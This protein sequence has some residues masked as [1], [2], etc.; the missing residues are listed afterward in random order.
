[1]RDLEGRLRSSLSREAASVRPEPTRLDDVEVRVRRRR[2]AARAVPVATITGAVLAAAVAVP[3]LLPRETTT[4]LGP[5]D[6]APQVQ[7]DPSEEAAPPEPPDSDE[8]ADEP[9]ALN[10]ELPTEPD[11]PFAPL[12]AVDGLLERVPAIVA[13]EDGDA[14]AA[15]AWSGEVWED[16][17]GGRTASG[18]VAVSP[19]AEGTAPSA[20]FP[21]EASGLDPDCET[22]KVL[23]G[24]GDE[25]RVVRVHGAECAGA[26]A[27]SPGGDRLAWIDGDRELRVVALAD[28]L[29]GDG[30]ATVASWQLDA[31]APLELAGWL[32]SPDEW[33]LLVIAGTGADAELHALPVAR[34]ADGAVTLPRRGLDEETAV[35]LDGAVPLAVAPHDSDRPHVSDVDVLAIAD[36]RLVIQAAAR[37]VRL[38]DS[39]AER[40]LDGEAEPWI[41]RHRRDVLVGDG[42]GA[43][44]HVAMPQTTDA[45]AEVVELDADWEAAAIVADGA[46]GP[47]REDA[48]GV[49][50][51]SLPDGI[52]D[53]ARGTW[54]M[55]ARVASEDRLDELPDREP[56]TLEVEVGGE[57]V[58]ALADPEALERAA[59]DELAA[60]L[61]AP[62]AG[63]SDGKM[64][65]WVFP[66]PAEREVES[67]SSAEREALGGLPDERFDPDGQWTGSEVRIRA[68]GSWQ[69]RLVAA[70]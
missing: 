65:A 51:A 41:T 1:M 36:R 56:E 26:P 31:G 27:I 58:D 64:R 57:R 34:E 53:E 17:D 60:V 37:E 32:S 6:P 70:P 24:S 5:G 22:L 67:L 25:P 10:G 20:S 30:E 61:G 16:V 28:V 3:A 21:V 55:L 12:A 11:A 39:V 38:P 42:H 43:V 40:V 2:V 13:V 15:S 29:A 7:Q 9:D 50:D 18:P 59:A 48:G 46:E 23:D 35:H 49:D 45:S 52:T 66:L 63:T 4:E 69:A 8:P 33:E 44:W 62:P 68:D 14:W 19:R 47:I 54:A